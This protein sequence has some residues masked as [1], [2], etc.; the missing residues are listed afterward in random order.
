MPELPRDWSR[1]AEQMRRYVEADDEEALATYLTDHALDVADALQRIPEL[2]RDIA[3]YI[4]VGEEIGLRLA[5]ANGR[6]DAIVAEL[7]QLERGT[8]I[9]VPLA[10]RVRDLRQRAE[11]VD[12]ALNHLLAAADRAA[13]NDLQRRAPVLFADLQR[14]RDRARAA[15]ADA[16]PCQCEDPDAE[17]RLDPGRKGCPI[18]GADRPA[19]RADASAKEAQ[20][21]AARDAGLARARRAA[22]ER[23]A[24]ARA[25]EDGD[26]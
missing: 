17:A 23:Y 24:D 26:G 10:Q 13:T 18:H 21:Q 2:E 11:R 4:R 15:L 5:R 1:F 16:P 25:E 12:E 14:A 7:P 22:H 19:R 8:A 6:L 20:R 9:G 3:D